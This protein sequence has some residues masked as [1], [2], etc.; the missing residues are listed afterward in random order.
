M[1]P[2]LRLSR[3]LVA[4]SWTE[5]VGRIGGDFVESLP[6]N[7]GWRIVL[8]DVSGHG[9]EAA[10]GARAARRRITADLHRSIDEEV[11]RAWNRDLHFV[12]VGR[13]VCLTLLELD[14]ASGRLIIANAGNPAVLVRRG[15]GQVDSFPG[16]GAVLGFLSDRE[17]LPPRF[18]ETTLDR[19]DQVLCFT[20]GLTDQPNARQEL[21]GL[22]R[23]VRL[24]PRLG[25]SPLRMLRR[26]VRAFARSVGW[27]D[28][29]TVLAIHA[30]Y[31]AA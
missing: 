3:D 5:C 8:G 15:E 14:P 16:T 1:L 2:R 6:R 11:L 19:A 12:L 18:V 28:D 26:S 21:F 7:G 22:E 23:L 25:Q 4:D 24:V 20:D 9:L 30:A 27:R 17:W 29:L 13:F 10:A 31:R